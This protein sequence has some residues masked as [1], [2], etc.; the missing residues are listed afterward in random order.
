VISSAP[1]R[2]WNHDRDENIKKKKNNKHNHKKQK[3]GE[4]EKLRR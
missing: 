4:S 3:K 1:I 2:R